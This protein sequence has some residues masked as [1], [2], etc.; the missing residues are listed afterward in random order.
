M[1]FELLGPKDDLESLGYIMIYI[2]NG[3]L[4]WQGQKAVDN[5]EKERAV[6]EKINVS[7]QHLCKGLVAAFI[8]YFDT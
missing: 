8:S 2:L 3:K 5:E 4:P 7:P 1:A 6:M